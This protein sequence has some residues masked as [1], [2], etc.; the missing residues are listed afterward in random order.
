[1][2]TERERGVADAGVG[3]E[4]SWLP[5]CV[6]VFSM[7][8]TVKFQSLLP[9]SPF[10]SLVQS[11]FLFFL[12][13]I[14][15]CSSSLLRKFSPFN[16]LLCLWFL[17]LSFSSFSSC[18]VACIYTHDGLLSWAAFGGGGGWRACNGGWSAL[19]CRQAF[20]RLSGA[21]VEVERQRRCAVAGR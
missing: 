7:Q 11:P 4:D 9:C 18:M 10:S 8:R 2:Q 3:E 20:R 12:R 6:F 16:S 14:L 17:L 19:E 21:E 1:M 15:S 13:K 5:L